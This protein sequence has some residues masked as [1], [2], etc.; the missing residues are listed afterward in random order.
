MTSFTPQ[1]VQP[2]EYEEALGLLFQFVP[3]EQDRHDRMRNAFELFRQQELDPEGFF[4]LREGDIVAGVLLCTTSPGSAGILWPPQSFADE[5]Q[6]QREDVLLQH[7]TRWLRTQGMKVIQVLL[8][9]EEQHLAA[10]LERNG[11]PRLTQ[12]VYMQRPLRRSRVARPSGSLQYTTYD[13]DPE[14]FHSILLASYEQTLDCPELNDV[15]PLEDILAGHRAQGVFDPKRWWLVSHRDEPVGVV[16]LAHLP[17]SASWD[18]A[19][20]GLTPDQRRQGF[21]REILRRIL[22]EAQRT[23]VHFVTLA[24]DVRN[25]PARRLYLSHGFEETEV[26]EVYLRIW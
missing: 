12:L 19:Y 26:R 18:L 16:M 2:H 5:H 1:P 23:D 22:V 10:P 6:E 14:T 21:G 7:A 17:E 15:R 20:I 8:A 3:S 4:L 24:V 25:E 11:F 9:P 13:R